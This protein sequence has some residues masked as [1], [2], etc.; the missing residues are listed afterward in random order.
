MASRA[1]K[2]GSTT[3]KKA[4]KA[5]PSAKVV[6]AKAKVKVKAKPVAKAKAKA[7][8]A[9]PQGVPAGYHTLTPFLNISGA[10]DAIEF[11]KKAFGATELYRMPGP[12]GKI[13]TPSSRLAIRG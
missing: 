3:K 4:V 9:K 6:K 2:S 1:K 10:A 12:D 11:Y 8:P 13:G 7:K 5:V